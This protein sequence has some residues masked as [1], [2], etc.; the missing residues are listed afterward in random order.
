MSSITGTFGTSKKCVENIQINF[1]YLIASPY[2][3]SL[4]SIIFVSD[5]WDVGGGGNNVLSKRIS[6]Q[7]YLLVKTELGNNSDLQA[8]L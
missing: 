3:T 1:P 7:L 6:V 8:E 4:C 2:Y 5:G